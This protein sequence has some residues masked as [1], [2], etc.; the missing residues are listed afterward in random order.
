MGHVYITRTASFLP[1][2]P[3][4]NDHMEE[5]LGFIDDKP[6]KSRRLVLRNNG[7]KTRYYAMTK[8][9]RPTHNNAQI[10][11]E[12][13]RRLTGDGLE[14]TDIDFMGT[15]TTSPDQVVPSH[16]SMIHGELGH[17]TMEIAGFQGSCCSSMNAMRMAYLG[18]RAGAMKTAAAVGSEMMSSWMRAENFQEE[19]R[20]AKEIEENPI[21]AF[22]K[23]FLRW[24]LSDGSGAALLQDKPNDQGIS[25]RIDWME[26]K[27]FA[28]QLDTCMYAGGDK[29]SDGRLTGWRQM[30][31]EEGMH[32]SVFSLKQDVRLL[33]DNIV[34]RG[35]DFLKELAVK[36]QMDFDKID[37]F[38]P[39]LSSN[40]F[41]QKIMDSLDSTGMS[42]PAEKWFTNLSKVG[43]VGAAS[44]F[45]M[46]DELF[47][48]G[49]LKSGDIIFM[50]IPESAR[51]TY[52]YVYLT[53]C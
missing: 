45:L 6:S 11:A 37:Y 44:P 49:R 33:G 8:D 10:A 20:S 17:A 32:K 22:E 3:I 23:D 27:S 38:L 5:Y 48:S 19:I 26:L 21:L 51:F 39:H 29:E 1:H 14:L 42:I 2:D 18:I 12:S 24:M 36:Y 25:L 47:H 4:D 50:M 9:G 28:N 13:I 16:A 46:L 43:N 30:S 35:N 34:E 7:I 15:G 40:F 31:P 53:V 41:R 52:A